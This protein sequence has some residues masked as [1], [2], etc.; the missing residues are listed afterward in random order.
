MKKPT[1][2]LGA[3]LG[4]SFQLLVFAQDTAPDDPTTAMTLDAGEPINSSDPPNNEDVSGDSNY[5]P[6]QGPFG[7]EVPESGESYE[8]PVGVTGIFNGNVSTGGSYDPLGHSAT[9]AIDDIVVPGTL[10]KYPLK[11][12]QQP[13]AILRAGL[14]CVEPWMVA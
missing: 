5:V 13:C 7:P 4:L 3:A 8:G 6:P 2:I 11:M 12:T 10:G 14:Y 1:I 9:R